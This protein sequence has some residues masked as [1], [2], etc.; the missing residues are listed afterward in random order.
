[1]GR[2][3]YRVHFG[4]EPSPA[5]DWCPDGF[6]DHRFMHAVLLGCWLGLPCGEPTQTSR[7][8]YPASWTPNPRTLSESSKTILNV[9][10]TWRNRAMDVHIADAGM[11]ALG[12]Q[13]VKE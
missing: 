11:A 13:H 12:M 1:V 10:R 2:E 7:M 6:H 8:R 4:Q 9:S 5:A 3:V